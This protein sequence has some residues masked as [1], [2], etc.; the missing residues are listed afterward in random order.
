MTFTSSQGLK[1][2]YFFFLLSPPSSNWYLTL[3][4]VMAVC[5]FAHLMT[6]CWPKKQNV[7][8]CPIDRN[9]FNGGRETDSSM[10][11]NIV[12]RAFIG[13]SIDSGKVL[14]ILNNFV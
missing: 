2:V 13:I 4:G 9:I 11:R 3:V 7:Y 1:G 6:K 10:N 14:T 5:R 12:I 8:I